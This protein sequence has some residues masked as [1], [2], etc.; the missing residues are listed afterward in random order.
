MARL[1]LITLIACA[2]CADAHA[3]Q[4]SR[5]T[6]VVAAAES[7]APSTVNI[8]STQKVADSGNPFVRGDPFFD[9]F[10]CGSGV[11]VEKFVPL[12]VPFAGV[13]DVVTCHDDSKTTG[14]VKK[15]DDWDCRIACSSFLSA[16]PGY[17]SSGYGSGMRGL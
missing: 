8:I 4:A 17:H 1:F 7:G 6:P 3:N 12:P 9:E 14:V 5:R 2:L 13:D 10:V 16:R 11:N 15:S